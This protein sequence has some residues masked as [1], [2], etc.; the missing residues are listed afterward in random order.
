MSV[1]ASLA[2]NGDLVVEGDSAGPVVI[3]ALDFDSYQVSDM[4]ADV[5]TID[6]VR[7]GIRVELDNTGSDVTLDLNYQKVKKN[8]IVD[9]W[10]R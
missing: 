4:G 1:M 9:L 3:T 10:R 7:R 8:V 6:G 5:G 2:S